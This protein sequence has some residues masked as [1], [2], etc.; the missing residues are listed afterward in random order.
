MKKYKLIPRDL[1][2]TAPSA[3]QALI[4]WGLEPT[5]PIWEPAAGRGHMAA[6]LRKRYKVMTS[7]IKQYP[8]C[9]RLD[10][11]ADFLSTR[12]TTCGTIITNPPYSHGL[13]DKFIRHALS[14]T[15][16]CNGIVC[17]LLKVKFDCAKTRRDIFVDHPAFRAKIV[18]TERMLIPGFRHRAQPMDH[19]S[20]FIWDWQWRGKPELYYA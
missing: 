18:L 17:M 10:F 12:S 19:H 15:E 11:V 5:G 1:Y 7:D 13:A 14:L 20:W 6:V 8:R 4:D 2:P 9:D 16:P 3:T